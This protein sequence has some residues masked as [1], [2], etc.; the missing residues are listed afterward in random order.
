MGCWL[1]NSRFVGRLVGLLGFCF[2]GEERERF[3]RPSAVEGVLA[4]ELG[5]FWGV[6]LAGFGGGDDGRCTWR[7]K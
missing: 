4:V 2:L 3:P 6:G 1:F 7:C 5:A